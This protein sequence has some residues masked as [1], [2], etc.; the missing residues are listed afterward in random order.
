MVKEMDG[1]SGRAPTVEVN[2]DL[3]EK[4]LDRFNTQVTNAARNMSLLMRSKKE[5]CYA[6]QDIVVQSRISL[7]K[8]DVNRAMI[9]ALEAEERYCSISNDRTDKDEA[10]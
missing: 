1:L 3:F 8:G 4:I 6:A 5:D 10:A 9:K 2:A 7:A